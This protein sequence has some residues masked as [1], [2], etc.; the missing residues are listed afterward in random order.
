M[1]TKKCKECDEIKGVEEFGKVHKG[2]YY[3]CY[4]KPCASK[5]VYKLKTRDIKTINKV[6]DYQKEYMPQYH[7][8]QKDGLHYVYLLKDHHYIGVTGCI[9][10]RFSLHRSKHNRNT[11]NYRIMYTTPDRAKALEVEKQYHRMGF[12]GAKT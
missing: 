4:C 9:K 2:K 1:E 5:V 3:N 6:K 8:K 10:T 12:F 11:D 7:E